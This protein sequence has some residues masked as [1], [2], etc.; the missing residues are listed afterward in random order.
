MSRAIRS[1]VSCVTA[2]LIVAAVVSSGFAQGAD[3]FAGGWKLNLSKS[4]FTPGPAPKSGTVMFSMAGKNVKVVVDGVAGDGT[5]THWEYTA[6]A[7][8]KDYAVTGNNPDADMIS[9]KQ[10]SP[11]SVQTTNK[12]GG[13]V[14]LTNV[15][16]V[17]ADGKTLTVTTKGT[18]AMGKAVNNVQVFDKM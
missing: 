7:D 2:G 3:P 11:R 15:R 1:V 18:N 12:K 8:G 9:L 6:M 5:K 14:T 13:K 17:S 10:A 4:K 16:T